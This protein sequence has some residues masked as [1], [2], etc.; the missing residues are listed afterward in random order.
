VEKYMVA[1]RFGKR[2]AEGKT[3]TIFTVLNDPELVFLVAKDDLTA[4]D[5][6]KHD[7]IV[8]K[9]KL[10]NET[11]CNVF[12]LLKSNGIPV[13][14]HSKKGARGFLATKCEMLSYEVIVRREAR[15]SYLKRNPE[16]E[17]GHRFDELLVEFFL[18]TSGR[19]WQGKSIPVDDPLMVLKD[20]V[21]YLYLPS[22]PLC[23][24]TPFAEFDGYP[25]RYEQMAEIAKKT[26]MILEQGWDRLGRKLVDF[27]VEFGYD[28]NNKLLLADVIDNDSWRLVDNGKYIDKQVYRSVEEVGGLYEQVAMLSKRLLY[29][30]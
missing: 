23:E 8:G 13:A 29:P 17:I 27:K 24:Q 21:S 5:G 22:V 28:V 3:K 20:E 16:L 6:A 10:A 25:P 11:T 2:I 9:G 1:Y 15:G 26:F 30:G 14:Y 4:G 12:T 7:I 19:K 18:K